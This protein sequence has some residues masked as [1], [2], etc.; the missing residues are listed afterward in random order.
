MAFEYPVYNLLVIGLHFGPL[1]PGVSQTFS[2]LFVFDLMDMP[3]IF[4]DNLFSLGFGK[5]TT[6]NIM[7]I[8]RQEIPDVLLGITIQIANP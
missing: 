2:D 5:F 4:P 7:K 6:Q 1:F 8:P 3:G